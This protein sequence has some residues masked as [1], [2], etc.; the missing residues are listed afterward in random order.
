MIYYILLSF[1]V[2]LALINT[3]AHENILS[4]VLSF[5]MI[6]CRVKIDFHQQQYSCHIDFLRCE[7]KNIFSDTIT[8]N[9][10]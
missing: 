3:S 9:Q 5:N 2:I 8:N 7:R 4:D 1:T 10:L 6:Q